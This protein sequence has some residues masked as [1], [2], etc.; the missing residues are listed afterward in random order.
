MFERFLTVSKFSAH[1][2]RVPPER[3]RI[4]YGG[5]DPE[6]FAPQPHERRRGVL[7]VGRLT[8]HK[9]IDRLLR[10][11]PDGAPLTVAGST[12]HDPLP[13]ERDYPLL[14]RRLAAGRNVRFEGPVPDRELPALHRRAAVFVL[15]SVE[16][17]CYGRHV[18][19]TELLG[20]SALEAMA[21]GTPVIASR[22]GGVPEI[23]RDGET[24]FLVTPGD[25]RELRYR[26]DL[27][28][29]DQRLARRMGMAARDAVVEQFTW[30]KTAERCLS[31]YGEL[32]GS[33]NPAT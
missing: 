31:A 23:I 30:A 7:Y 14:L 6:R 12:G 24:G 29:R 8:P 9:G 21:S 27:L 3:T 18:S 10:A 15:P 26:L 4:L 5:A 22:T 16:T 2:L 13:P 20:L 25:E 28:L 32:V 33:T 19:I 1:V 17:T 11:L